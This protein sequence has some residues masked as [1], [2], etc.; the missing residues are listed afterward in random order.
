MASVLSISLAHFK[1]PPQSLVRSFLKSRNLWRTRAKEQASRLEQLQSQLQSKQRENENLHGQL[2]IARKEISELQA[3]DQ[4]QPSAFNEKPLPGH[5]YGPAMIALCCRLAL[6]IGFRAVPKVLHCISETWDIEMDI[7]SRDAVRNWNSRNGV[8]IL[9]EAEKADDWIWMVDHSVQLGKMFVLVVLGIRR[10]DVPQGRPL[11][12]QDMQTLAVLPTT[13]RTADEVSQQLQ[14]VAGEF[15]VPIAVLCDGASELRQGVQ[16]LEKLGF[17]GVIL[18]DVKHKIAN[19]LKRTVGK[20]EW[21]KAFE[22]ELGKTSAMIAQ[23]ELEHL[24]P[25]RKKQKSRFMD[26]DRLIDWAMKVQGQLDA[27]P[28]ATKSSARLLEKLG[29][30]NNYREELAAW[31]QVRQMIGRTLE[32]TNACGVWIGS[33][34]ELRGRLDGFSLSPEWVRAFRCELLAIN[35]HNASQLELL[36]PENRHLPCSTEMLESAFGSFKAIQAHHNRGTFTSLLA[37]FATLFDTCKAAKIR[38]RFA[39]VSNQDLKAWLKTAG[40]TDSTQ[41]KRNQLSRP[42]KVALAGGT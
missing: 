32:Q 7:P 39:R 28:L 38:E 17:C 4:R 5:Q 35:A 11:R 31:Q 34:E 23:T 14:K 10:S 42:A 6:L 18:D 25:P 20:Q 21:W 3:S 24:L 37:T 9:Q 40:L 30:I 1:S 26:F 27:A 16:S 19:L 22:A 41:S 29:W 12:R 36:T 13:S 33:T 15:G 2:Q 8:A